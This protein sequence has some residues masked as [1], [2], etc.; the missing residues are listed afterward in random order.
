ME[1]RYL[2]VHERSDPDFQRDEQFLFWREEDEL[3]LFFNEIRK[4]PSSFFRFF[5]SEQNI[6][7]YN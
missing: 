1:P 4:E 7:N 2:V 6:I 3:L 5:F